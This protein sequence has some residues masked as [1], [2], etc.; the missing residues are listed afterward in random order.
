MEHE[1]S[2]CSEFSGDRSEF[3]NLN[4]IYS[5]KSEIIIVEVLS[6]DEILD[7]RKEVRYS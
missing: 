5:T 4:K 7:D 2:S 1:V 6:Y 3:A